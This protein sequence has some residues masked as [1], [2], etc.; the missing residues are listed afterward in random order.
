MGTSALGTGG[1]SGVL[2][3]SDPLSLLVLRESKVVLQRLQTQ[4]P[5][6]ETFH[7]HDRHIAGIRSMPHLRIPSSEGSWMAFCQHC[8]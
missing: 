2:G 5:F 1:L 7:S 8:P 4:F 3:L 6:L